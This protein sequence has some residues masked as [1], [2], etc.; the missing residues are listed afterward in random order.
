MTRASCIA[1][2]VGISPSLQHNLV[3]RIYKDP[4]GQKN[5]IVKYKIEKFT[6]HP[7]FSPEKQF[8]DLAI[9]KHTKQMADYNFSSN[10]AEFYPQDSP[11]TLSIETL[12]L[13]HQNSQ[14][15]YI[16]IYLSMVNLVAAVWVLIDFR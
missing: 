5:N 4:Q 7:E 12:N 9:L 14:T 11:G 1:L 15:A 3:T 10:L 6:I 8:P 2:S 16:S 13:G